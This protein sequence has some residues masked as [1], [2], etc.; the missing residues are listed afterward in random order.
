MITAESEIMG[1][2]PLPFWKL[3]QWT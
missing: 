1:G 3:L 2:S